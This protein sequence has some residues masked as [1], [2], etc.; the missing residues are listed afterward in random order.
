MS[1]QSHVS[2]FRT[3]FISLLSLLTCLFFLICIGAVNTQCLA[4]QVT[5]AWD[6]NAYPGMAA[7]YKLYYGYA[8]RTY[9]TPVDVGNITQ[10]TLTGIQEGTNCYFTVTAYDTYRNESTFSTEMECFTLMPAPGVNGTIS[11]SSAAVVSRGMNQIF[12]ITPAA[13]YAIADVLVN[14][15]SVGAVPSYTFSNV[16][17]NYSISASFTTSQPSS[18]A[19]T[20]SAGT[21]G[22]ISPSGSISVAQGATQIFSITPN[23]GCQVQDVLVDGTSVG[24]VNSY[25]FSNAARSP[26]CILIIV[27]TLFLSMI[28][29][30]FVCTYIRGTI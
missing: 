1:Y 23:T 11:P 24:K 14:G 12:T 30:L 5:L 20:A 16:S 7:G 21:N 17:A 6:A 28:N 26:F 27:S 10:Y 3:G 15:V 9:G 8:S 18:Y 4:A 22:A 25:T 19:I 13:N 29:L 2:R